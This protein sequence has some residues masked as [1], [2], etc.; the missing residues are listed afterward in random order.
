MNITLIEALGIH[1]VRLVTR[2]LLCTYRT[3]QWAR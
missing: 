1:L 2:V 3:M